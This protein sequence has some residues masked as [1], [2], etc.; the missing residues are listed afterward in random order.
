LNASARRQFIGIGGDR[1]LSRARPC[2]RLQRIY[3]LR[4]VEDM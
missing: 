3:A 4:L 1:Q 2:K